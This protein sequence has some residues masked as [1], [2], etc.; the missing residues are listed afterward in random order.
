MFSGFNV[1]I[2]FDSNNMFLPNGA[3][4]TPIIDISVITIL[5]LFMPLSVFHYFRSINIRLFSV[6]SI[7]Y[8]FPRNMRVT[9]AGSI[10]CGR[11]GSISSPF[12]F[13]FMPNIYCVTA[14]YIHAAVPVSQ[15]T[16]AKPNLSLSGPK[17][18]DAYTYGSAL[19]RHSPA[20]PC[21][22]IGSS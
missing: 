5:Y 20:F 4:I 21:A 9:F 14:I 18:F 17:M 11:H 7:S 15:L 2:I 12:H 13:G 8:F 3:I 6:I 19:Y 16:F 22:I 10:S 1:F